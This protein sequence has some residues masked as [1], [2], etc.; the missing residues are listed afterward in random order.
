MRQHAGQILA[1]DSF[2]V[3]TV[4]LTRLY[5]LFFMETRSRKST[6]PASRPIRMSTPGPRDRVDANAFTPHAARQVEHAERLA[7]QVADAT[8]FVPGM[9]SIVTCCPPFSVWPVR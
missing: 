7:G 9:A 3:E 2:T 6:W 1:C 4:C 8:P 5:V